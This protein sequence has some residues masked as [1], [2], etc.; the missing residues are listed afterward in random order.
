MKIISVTFLLLGFFYASGQRN[1]LVTYDEYTYTT[2]SGVP[3][4]FA[5][6]A[7]SSRKMVLSQCINLVLEDSLYYDY[8]E[9]SYE[10]GKTYPD[11]CKVFG[12]KAKHHDSFFD[13]KTLTGFE[14]WKKTAKKYGYRKYKRKVLPVFVT[15]R[16]LIVSG[17]NC[18]Q[19]YYINEWKD[20]LN[21]V[22][23]EDERYPKISYLRGMLF[24]GLVIDFYWPERNMSVSLSKIKWGDFRIEIPN[25][26]IVI[27]KVVKGAVIQNIELGNH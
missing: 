7:D 17:I 24:P 8:N 6:P 14:F 1:M 13:L 18:V 9:N 5:H 23:S 10:C 27:P 25:L 16:N 11:T 22:I 20:T 3:L 19:G 26:E 2:A 12:K 15:K 4:I 21:L